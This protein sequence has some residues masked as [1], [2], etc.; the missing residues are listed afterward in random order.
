MGIVQESVC[1]EGQSVMSHRLA[2][3]SRGRPFSHRRRWR[4]PS[5][6]LRRASR[7]FR[8]SRRLGGVLGGRGGAAATS[9]SSMAVDRFWDS[10]RG[11]DSVTL[12]PRMGIGKTGSEGRGWAVC[13]VQVAMLAVCSWL[14]GLSATA[15]LG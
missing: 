13:S 6:P 2:V 3:V 8:L 9:S 15:A 10:S 4:L 7:R 5:L 14:K 12:I 11:M 1:R